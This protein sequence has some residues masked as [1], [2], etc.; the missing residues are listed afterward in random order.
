MKADLVPENLSLGRLLCLNKN[1]NEPGNINGIRPIAIMS[2]IIKICE[3]P[4]LRELKKV[5]LN[6][7][8]I[9]F[10][11]GMGCEV[12]ILRFRQ[13]VHDLRYLNYKRNKKMEKRYLLFVDLKCAFDSVS[14]PILIKKLIIKGIPG[15]SPGHPGCFS[16]G[17][18]RGR[19]FLKPTF[20]GLRQAA[21]PQKH[22]ELSF[23]VR[24]EGPE[25][26]IAGRRARKSDFLI[27]VWTV[28]CQDGSERDGPRAVRPPGRQ[29]A[30]GRRSGARRRR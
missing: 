23:C 20:C 9:G 11:Q 6:I 17:A 12:N 24:P 22:Q 3:I 10:L 15:L 5:K 18:A 2:V 16:P 8:Q 30:V 26:E 21:E 7:N 4:L 14:I 27:L 25:Q 13:T 29:R 19:G 1:A 28:F